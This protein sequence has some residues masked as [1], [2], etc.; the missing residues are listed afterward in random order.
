[1]KLTI[2][3]QHD[4]YEDIKKVLHILTAII[5]H[6]DSSAPAESGDQAVGQAVDTTNLMDMFSTP[7]EKPTADNPPSFSSFLNLTKKEE[8]K[9]PIPKIEFF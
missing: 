2:D 7:T 9:E 5:E 8:K 6:K 1:M 4:S 3:T